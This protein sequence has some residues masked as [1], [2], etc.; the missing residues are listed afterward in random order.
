MRLGKPMEASVGLLKLLGL[1]DVAEGEPKVDLH[2]LAHS[3]DAQLVEEIAAAEGSDIPGVLGWTDLQWVHYIYGKRVIKPGTEEVNGTDR[4][5]NE[6]PIPPEGSELA[7]ILDAG[8]DATQMTAIMNAPIVTTA[9]LHRA[10]VLALRLYSS[11]LFEKINKPLHDGCSP[12]RPHPY[13]AMVVVLI[14]A[15]RKLRIAQAEE[16]MQAA[17]AKADAEAAVEAAKVAEDDDMLA[18]AQASAAEA[19]ATAERLSNQIFWRG[20]CALSNEFKQ[21]GG[22]EIGFISLTRDR[23]LAQEQALSQHFA[24]EQ[25]RQME[26]ADLANQRESARA[27]AAAL[28]AEGGSFSNG[29]G[30]CSFTHASGS[31][32][33]GS[34]SGSFVRERRVSQDSMGG[35]ERR[36]S[37]ESMGGRSVEGFSERPPLRRLDSQLGGG[38]L[39][40]AT[41]AGET[42]MLLLKVRAEFGGDGED[43]PSDISAFSVFPREQEMVFPPG[44]Y[45]EH[46][47][48]W[49]ETID[50]LK[51]GGM[52]GQAKVVECAPHMPRGVREGAGHKEK[53]A[54]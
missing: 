19:T 41:P 5:N 27:H 52:E 10:H 44:C 47:R 40:A 32:T 54:K 2:A 49:L 37:Q 14:D 17:T 3:T 11:P 29:H 33:H 22:T 4:V 6:R 46:K 7:E 13:P 53:V 31:F 18:A 20:V 43:A 21:R 51:T 38:G 25:A 34:S 26:I 45:L 28:A 36:V 48:E 1:D 12:E 16:R 23:A 39:P 9:G 30:S 15:L 8:R 50:Q 24:L 42:P 35:G